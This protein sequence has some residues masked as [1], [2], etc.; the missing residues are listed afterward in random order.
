MGECRNLGFAEKLS[1]RL[2]SMTTMAFAIQAKA[3]VFPLVLLEA[4]LEIAQAFLVF[5]MFFGDAFLYGLGRE[6]ILTIKINHNFYC[7]GSF[8]ALF[9]FICG[10]F[11]LGY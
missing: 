9:E 7:K 3:G 6:I 11:I 2:F 1:V 10:S 5:A 8:F 4:K